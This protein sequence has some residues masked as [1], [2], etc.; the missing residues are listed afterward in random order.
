MSEEALRSFVTHAPTEWGCVHELNDDVTVTVS[1][2]FGS[3]HTDVQDG[4]LR[5]ARD[6]KG[7]VLSGKRCEYAECRGV[8]NG[9]RMFKMRDVKGLGAL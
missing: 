7:K 4:V 6:T 3:G 2:K 8:E 9:M 5:T 1:P